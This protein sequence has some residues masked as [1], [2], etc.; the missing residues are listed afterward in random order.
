VNLRTA[1]HLEN[2]HRARPGSRKR[3]DLGAQHLAVRP[4]VPA[5]IPHVPRG[6]GRPAAAGARQRGTPAWGAQLL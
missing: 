5:A 1:A 2:G 3:P 4:A 6:G